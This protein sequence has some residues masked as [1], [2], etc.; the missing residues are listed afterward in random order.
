MGL[1]LKRGGRQF[2]GRE[3]MSLEQEGDQTSQS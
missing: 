2:T 1:G 3:E